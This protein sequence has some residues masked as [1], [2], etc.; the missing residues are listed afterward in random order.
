MHL[1]AQPGCHGWFLICGSLRRREQKMNRAQES[2]ELWSQNS[3]CSL[4]PLLPPCPLVPSPA[5][6]STHSLTRVCSPFSQ[7]LS[8]HCI[9]LTTDCP[10]RAFHRCYR[11]CDSSLV[12]TKVFIIMRIP[13][14]V[15]CRPEG[16]LKHLIQFYIGIVTSVFLSAYPSDDFSI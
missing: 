4:C 2:L 3:S 7:L 6:V 1:P 8:Y 9:C 16:C 10:S 13:L 12:R 14:S 11:F 15:K 5:N